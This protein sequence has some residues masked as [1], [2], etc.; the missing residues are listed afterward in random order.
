[1]QLPRLPERLLRKDDFAFVRRTFRSDGLPEGEIDRYV[2][3][4]RRE[5]ALRGGINYYRAAMRAAALGRLPRFRRIESPVL[6][7]WGEKDK[8][9]GR[10]MAR[11]DAEWVPNARVEFVPEASHWVQRDAPDKVNALLVDFLRPS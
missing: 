10:E 7:I 11:P 2:E 4:L 5:G 8:S 6:V 3:A 1:F 9:L